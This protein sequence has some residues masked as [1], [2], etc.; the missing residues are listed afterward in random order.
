M[1]LALKPH[2]VIGPV[3]AKVQALYKKNV[4]EG[5]NIFYAQPLTD[6]HLRSDLKWELEPNSTALYIYV[7]S[8]IALFVIAI[9]CVNYINLST[10]KASSAPRRSGSFAKSPAPCAAR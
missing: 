5:K 1:S 4:K 3:V 7:F 10:A 2:T 8:V 6:I 9:A